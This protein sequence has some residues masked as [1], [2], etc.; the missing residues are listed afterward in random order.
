[1]ATVQLKNFKALEYGARE[2]IN[3]LCTNL[4]FVGGD[5]RKIIVTSYRP[6]EGKSFV[7]MNLMRA[8][9]NIGRRVLMIDADLRGSMLRYEYGIES[10]DGY[11]FGLTR[12]LAGKCPVEAIIHTTNIPNADI[13]LSGRTVTNSMPLINSDR[14]KAL[15]TYVDD[16]Y[17]IV[18]VDAPPVGTIIDAARI[19]AYCDGTLYVAESGA[20]TPQE[21]RNG[22]QQM[23]RAGSTILGVV[24]NKYQMNT[25]KDYYYYNYD[26]PA[27]RK[28][29][30]K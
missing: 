25:D 10:Q 23:E 11:L 3:T 15:F 8:F 14:L 9:A 28:K 19:A 29:R 21:L 24:L 7:S 26:K 2:A 20:E 13:I 16:Q 18:I 27:L 6:S 5:I 17:D 22:I 4:S 12:Y 30:G 1:M